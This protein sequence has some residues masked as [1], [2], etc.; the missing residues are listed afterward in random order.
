MLALIANSPLLATRPQILQARRASTP[1]R[2]EVGR[3][4]ILKQAPLINLARLANKLF[5]APAW[6]GVC[7][8]SSQVLTNCKKS[9]RFIDELGRETMALQPISMSHLLFIRLAASG[10]WEWANVFFTEDTQEF[11]RNEMCQHERH[12]SAPSNSCLCLP[13][14]KEGLFHADR[15][16]SLMNFTS[17][18]PLGA[19]R[20]FILRG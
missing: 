19:N 15:G 16:V 13:E 18:T 4:K 1:A 9:H 7:L 2:W 12:M 3:W 20:V 6:L 17:Q 10:R 8:E 11:E 14:W 5:G